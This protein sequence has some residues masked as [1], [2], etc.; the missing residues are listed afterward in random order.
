MTGA[1]TGM[2]WATDGGKGLRAGIDVL[3][4]EQVLDPMV[5]RLVAAFPGR[6]TPRD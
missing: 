3:V 5:Q 4:Q 6:R 2:P 1:G